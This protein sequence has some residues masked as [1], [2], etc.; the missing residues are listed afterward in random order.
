MVMSPSPA[1]INAKRLQK[2]WAWLV[3]LSTK[4]IMQQTPLGATT[5]HSHPQRNSG[6]ILTVQTNQL[7][8]TG[9]SFVAHP[10]PHV[11][12]E[13]PVSVDADAH[14]APQ[15]ASRWWRSMAS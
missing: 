12:A 10:A 11:D 14:P 8:Q 9:V 5:G 2:A 15:P 13:A 7:H 3:Q 4:A 6:S 1:V